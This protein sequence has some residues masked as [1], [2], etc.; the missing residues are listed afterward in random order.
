MTELAGF[1]KGRMELMQSYGTVCLKV[2]PYSHSGD[3]LKMV[4]STGLSGS[5]GS[6]ALHAQPVQLID[7]FSVL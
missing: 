5:C 3:F 6:P 4:R 2:C 7:L 1:S